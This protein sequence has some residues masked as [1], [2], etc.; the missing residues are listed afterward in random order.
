MQQLEIEPMLCFHFYL[1]LFSKLPPEIWQTSCET[2]CIKIH[3]CH[4]SFFLSNG[5]VFLNSCSETNSARKMRHAL[6]N[7]SAFVDLSVIL[8]FSSTHMSR[9]RSFQIQIFLPFESKGFTKRIFLL[10]ILYG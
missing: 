5:C 3:I 10:E 7:S 4:L 8:N 1:K 9:S 2:A 6:L